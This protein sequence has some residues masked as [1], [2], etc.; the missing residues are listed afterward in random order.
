MVKY[1]PVQLIGRLLIEQ[2]ASL[3]KGMNLTPHF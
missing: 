3:P 2:L 1:E